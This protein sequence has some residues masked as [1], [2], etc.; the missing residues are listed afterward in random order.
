[1]VSRETSVD[2]GNACAFMQ[3]TD[4]SMDPGHLDGLPRSKTGSRHHWPLQHG[5]CSDSA[6]FALA[7]VPLSKVLEESRFD[8]IPGAL[9]VGLHYR[10]LIVHGSLRMYERQARAQD[11][12]R[13]LLRR[14]RWQAEARVVHEVCVS[15]LVFHATLRISRWMVR[16]LRSFL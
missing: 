9:I 15:T 8:S 12:G 4:L 3:L 2:H 10:Y 5:H 1:M 16:R 13:M 11:N 6:A 7:I 14:G